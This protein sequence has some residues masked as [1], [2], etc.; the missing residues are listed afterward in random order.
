MTYSKVS[1]LISLIQWRLDEGVTLKDAYNKVVINFHEGVTED[2]RQEL[3]NHF[4]P[5]N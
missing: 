2:E 1:T 4:S 5:L 3:L